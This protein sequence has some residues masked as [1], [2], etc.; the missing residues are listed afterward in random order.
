MVVEL[1]VWDKLLENDAEVVMDI[2]ADSEDD[3]VDDILVLCDA[4]V[5]ADLLVL[6]DIV[7]V[8]L[9]LDDVVADMVELDEI[10]ADIL[11]LALTDIDTDG[12]L[13]NTE[14]APTAT[15]GI[16]ADCN[17]FVTS[18]GFVSPTV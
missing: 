11:E 10:V 3:A 13:E 17:Q 12:E 14:P 15:N 18:G 1:D 16:F 6:W 5:V 7:V 2:V 9:E 8:I 4:I